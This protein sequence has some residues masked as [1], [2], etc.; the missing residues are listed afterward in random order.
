MPPVAD[1]GGTILFVCTGNVCRSPY[2][3]LMLRNS[4]GQKHITSIRVRS[5]GTDAL[6]RQ[7]I[8]PPMAGILADAG[9]NAD[10]FRS[11]QLERQM[12]RSAD[13]ILTAERSH[14]A[15]VAR[16][17]PSALP[18]IF[19]LRQAAR[20]LQS[21]PGDAAIDADANAVTRLA[22]LIAAGRGIHQSSAGDGDDV[23]DPW[24]QSLSTYRAVAGM[25]KEPLEVLTNVIAAQRTA[26]SFPAGS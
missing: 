11:R 25:L 19:T 6:L 7:P 14:R 26:P 12:V 13:L 15:V 9:I 4:L 16:L 21:G 20:L 5:A 22:A 23:P 10:W 8:A 17:Q 3:E 2:L 1:P 18:R 24:Q